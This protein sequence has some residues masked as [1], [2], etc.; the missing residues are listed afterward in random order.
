MEEYIMTLRELITTLNLSGSA[1]EIAAALNSKTVEVKDTTL[2]TYSW[3]ASL[4]G[5][6]FVSTMDSILQAAGLEWVRM[7]LTGNGIDFSHPETIAMVDALVGAGVITP[8]QASA[9]KEIGIRYISPYEQYFGEGSSVTEEMVAAALTPPVVERQER[10]A[11]IR[12]DGRDSVVTVQIHEI[13]KDGSRVIKES[14][15]T[16]NANPTQKALLDQLVQTLNNYEGNS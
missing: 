4:Y 6:D 3:I 5:A 7:Q 10:I 14:F 11:T 16:H 8:D 13:Y 15:S 2:H 9:I 12:S 1:T